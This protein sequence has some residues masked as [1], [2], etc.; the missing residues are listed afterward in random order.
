MKLE[1]YFLSV[2]LQAGV[3]SLCCFL[4]TLCIRQARWR[5]GFSLLSLLATALLSWIVLPMKPKPSGMTPTSTGPA[6]AQ[7]AA[8]FL[9]D[10]SAPRDL[11]LMP[12]PQ[13]FVSVDRQKVPA[14][15]RPKSGD[16]LL[17][18]LTDSPR[19]QVLRPGPKLSVGGD[20]PNTTAVIDRFNPGRTLL[21][22][23]GS[24]ALVGLAMLVF[25][26]LRIARWH[27]SMEQPDDDEWAAIL[28]ACP[29]CGPRDGFRLGSGDVGPALAGIWHPRI[30]IPRFLLKPAR[31]T[32]LAWAL[33]HEISHRD[34][35]DT[36]WAFATQIIRTI[37]WWNPI[38]HLLHRVW[39]NAREQ[40]C[41]SA[42]AA[43]AE[44]RAAYGHFLV[45]L[46]GQRYVCVVAMAAA[47]KRRLGRRIGSLLDA[48]AGP[49]KK[50]SNLQRILSSGFCLLALL[51]ATRFG[52]M[53][54]VAAVSPIEAPI[55]TDAPSEIEQILHPEK[56][57]VVSAGVVV[58][59]TAFA[60]HGQLFDAASLA[61]HI[62]RYKEQLARAQA[63]GSPQKLTL[64]PG[65]LCIGPLQRTLWTNLSDY[66]FSSHG[67]LVAPW[68]E[69]CPVK[70]FNGWMASHSYRPVGD[71]FELSLHAAYSFVAGHHPAPSYVFPG[72]PAEEMVE[73]EEQATLASGQAMAFP[74]GEVEPGVHVS[75]ILGLNAVDPWDLPA[76]REA[77]YFPMLQLDEPTFKQVEVKM[78]T[79]KAYDDGT[80]LPWVD[81]PE[82][83]ELL[84]RIVLARER[85]PGNAELVHHRDLQRKILTEKPGD[86]GAEWKRDQFE[87][88]IYRNSDKDPEVVAM[89]TELN[90]LDEPARRAA[91]EF[92]RKREEQ[93]RRAQE[94]QMQERRARG[95]K[96]LPSDSY[97]P[98][99]YRGPEQLKSLDLDYERRRH[100]W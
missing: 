29:E 87:R 31:Q 2:A 34:G 96:P 68:D 35:H 44:E 54:P 64:V 69:D 25:G 12:G 51:L 53:P 100:E 15:D 9:E 24:G 67:A 10:P 71:T 50:A 45:S 47:S 46:A 94:E 70:H 1:T 3:I 60:E 38:V 98:P 39:T 81:S 63:A 92:M 59:P 73:V 18:I 52:F 14:V 57:M 88:G 90:R 80:P 41:D 32:E 5:A 23:W 17:D 33:R 27:R 65:P 79:V 77:K 26:A 82:R 74:M 91:F 36:R 83:K 72:H 40:V 19:V 66:Y 55:A 62:R 37:F 89:M 16:T 21:M 97:Q 75:L 30:I 95:A 78:E 8:V 58:S 22:L 11:T 13:S 86:L 4:V 56:T 48:P 99:V 7:E 84:T 43:T 28:A 49:L 6:P 42:A 76:A 20:D 93:W 85:C 61:N